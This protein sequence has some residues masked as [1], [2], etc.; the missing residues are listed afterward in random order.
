MDLLEK[1]QFISKEK[2]VQSAFCPILIRQPF[3]EDFH[4]EPHTRFLD[5]KDI[6]LSTKK[7]YFELACFVWP[8][9]CVNAVEFNRDETMKKLKF[10]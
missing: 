2:L 6:D 5:S 7:L 9:V 3:K 8:K 4:K 1:Y 10:N